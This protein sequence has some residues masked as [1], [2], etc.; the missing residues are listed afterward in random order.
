MSGNEGGE[1]QRKLLGDQHPDVA[2]SLSTFGERMRQRGNLNESQTVL[3]AATTSSPQWISQFDF[4][5]DLVVTPGQAI[6]VAGN[7]ATLITAACSIVWA[8]VSR[9]ANP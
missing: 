1:I 8:E 3:T 9:A 2:K 4:D 5:G 7:I 6:F